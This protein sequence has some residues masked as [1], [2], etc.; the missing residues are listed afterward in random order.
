MEVLVVGGAES[1]VNGNFGRKLQ[2]HGVRIGG[3]VPY[4]NGNTHRGVDG[5]PQSCEGVVVI[6]DMVSHSTSGSAKEAARKLNLPFVEVPRKW[7]VAE[8]HLRA[9]GI[10]PPANGSAPAAV[11]PTEIEAVTLPH[12]ITICESGRKPT[13][14]EIEVLVQR[15]FGADKELPRAVFDRVV[16]VAMSQARVL[17]FEAIEETTA[18]LLVLQPELVLNRAALAEEVATI[19][20][21]GIEASTLLPVVNRAA[22]AVRA[23]WANPW[24]ADKPVRQQKAEAIRDWLVR[25]WQEFQAGKRPYPDT[26]T[27]KGEARTIFQTEP[28]WDVVRATRCQVLGVW[29]EKL[30]R[31]DLV[32]K[33]YKTV[34][35]DF[36][37]LIEAGKI[38]S[39]TSKSLRLTSRQ[40][41][42]DYLATVKPAIDP[43]EA[44]VQAR[45]EAMLPDIEARIE[46]R[47]LARLGF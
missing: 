36:M 38:A 7:S 32:A 10:L 33:T 24:M 42:E 20:A 37:A 18:T 29:A 3:H 1:L 15:A 27:L 23:K 8:P 35:P 17:P 25:V 30:V 12:I 46:A 47:V 5:I 22:D 28:D 31:A 41:A 13:L 16:G 21:W 6:V 39:V 44:L 2:E 34:L 40:A 26:F 4:K 45:I 19:G 43:I 11:T 14:P 9:S